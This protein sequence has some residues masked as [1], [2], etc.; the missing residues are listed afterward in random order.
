MRILNEWIDL[1]NLRSENYVQNSRIPTITYGTPKEDAFRRDLTINA[2]F[3]NI[4]ESKVEDFT[5]KV[6]LRLFLI[7]KIGYG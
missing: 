5:E 2:L 6:F 4:N 3:Y 7:F 1:V